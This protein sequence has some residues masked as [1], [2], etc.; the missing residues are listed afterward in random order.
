MDC[1][2]SALPPSCD[3]PALAIGEMVMF[4]SGLYTE[5]CRGSQ[6]KHFMCASQTALSDQIYYVDVCVCVCMLVCFSPY[7]VRKKLCKGAQEVHL[8]GPTN[9]AHFTTDWRNVTE[10][11]IELSQCRSSSAE[12]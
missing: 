1:A 11:T 8:S 6:N 2:G 12:K 7:T 3:N 9:S 10:S 5:V 4:K